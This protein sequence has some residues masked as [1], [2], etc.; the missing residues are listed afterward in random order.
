MAVPAPRVL[1]LLA[2]LALLQ[3]SHAQFGMGDLMGM[4]QSWPFQCQAPVALGQSCVEDYDCDPT[5]NH[6]C[7]LSRRVCAEGQPEGAPCNG[8]NGTF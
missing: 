4:F 3:L 2:A 7:H 6:H 8:G 1:L 5:Q